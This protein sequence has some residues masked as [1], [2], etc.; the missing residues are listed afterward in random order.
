[1][2]SNDPCHWPIVTSVKAIESLNKTVGNEDGV[3]KP[4]VAIKDP[5]KGPNTRDSNTEMGI[6]LTCNVRLVYK[7]GSSQKGTLT[8]AYANVG[9]FP[10]LARVENPWP[11]LYSYPVNWESK[12]EFD[13]KNAVDAKQMYL[14][15]TNAESED[16]ASTV[17]IPSHC[18]SKEAIQYEKSS[19]PSVLEAGPGVYILS[20]KP[21]SDTGRL[22][23]WSAIPPRPHYFLS[24][25]LKVKWN[26][27]N[28]DL[29]YWFTMWRE[30]N[31]QVMTYYGHKEYIPGSQTAIPGNYQGF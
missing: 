8:F 23:Y 29:G 20:I 30:P 2:V 13:K 11:V 31:G 6:G 27:G 24:C 21:L 26:N 10:F 14:I 7:D 22:Q 18:M 12:E 1:M 25:V 9:M 28:V 16:E 3:P 5:H 19:I 4:V 15:N 17:H